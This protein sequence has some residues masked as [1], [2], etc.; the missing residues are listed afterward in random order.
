MIILSH[1][2]VCCGCRILAC[3]N[4]KLG[5]VSIDPLIGEFGVAG[6]FAKVA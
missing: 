6:L 5:S 4:E 2:T 3:A 1:F